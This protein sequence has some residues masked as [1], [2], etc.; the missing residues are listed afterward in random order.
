MEKYDF[1]VQ[2][3]YGE[4][5]P[6]IINILNILQ[7][8]P[9]EEAFIRKFY[10]TIPMFSLT[11]DDSNLY[12]NLVMNAFHFLQ[13]HNHAKA[14]VRVYQGIAQGK[15]EDHAIIEIL[16]R[17]IPFLFDSAICLLNRLNISIERAAHPNIYVRRDP[18]G[19]L[20]NIDEE[21]HENGEQEILIQIRTLHAL[22]KETSLKVESELQNILELVEN[23]VSD[24]KKIVTT[25]DDYTNY[26]RQ[27]KLTNDTVLFEEQKEFLEKM[28]SKYFIFL[29][30]AKYKFDKNQ[31]TLIENSTLGTLKPEH[32]E[33]DPLIKASIFTPSFFE[34]EHGLISIGK[35]NKISVIHRDA[36][37]DYLCVKTLD[38]QGNLKEAIV[39]IGLFTSILYY[40]SA[41]LIPIIRGKLHHVLN[42]AGF[43]SHSYAGKEIV[44]IVESLPRDELFQI[45]TQELYLLVMEIYALLFSPE[46][47]LFTRKKGD[48]LGCLLFLPL[49]IANAENSRKLKTA[50]SFEY[51]T[52]VSEHFAQVNSSRLGYY[53]FNIDSRN[54]KKETSDLVTIEKELISITKPWDES[55]REILLKE[56]GKNK[57]AG[58]FYN[59]KQA[60]PTSYKENSNYIKTIVGDIENILKILNNREIIFNISPFIEGKSNLAQF[61]IYN[62][63]ELNLSS[64]MPMLNNIG[65][66]VVAEQIH[67]ISPESTNDEIWLHQFILKADNKTSKMIELAKDN[68]EEAFYAMWANKFQNNSY[69][70]LILEANLNYKQITL[71]M[72]LA[73]YLC[74]IKIGYSKEYIGE[75][76]S[77]HSE[78]AKQLISL[79]Y[80]MFNHDLSTENRD[81]QS[82][83]F[84]N[85]L[86]N[87]LTNIQDNIE[88]QII[89][90][91]INL[92]SNILR[93]NYFLN[94]KNGDSKNFMSFKLNSKEI[95]GMPLP[96]PYREIFV[97]SATFEAIHLRGG[98][99]ARGGLRWSD[100]SEDYRTEVLGLMKTQVVKNSVIVPTGSKGGFLLKGTAGLDREALQAKA[101]ESYENFLRGMLDITDN[102]IDGKVH[103]PKNIVRYDESDPYL[104]VAADKGTATFSDIANKI[105]AEYGFW[106]GDAFASGG[107]KGYDHKKMGITAK[108][109]WISVTRHFHE[110][111]INIENTDF[112]VIGVGDMSG[113]V[114]GNG[115]L[116]SEHIRL[117]GAFN[118]LHIFI[119]P[120]P[121]SKESYKER[122]RLF[123]LP[124]STWLDYNASILSKGGQI[125]DRKAKLLHLTPEIKEAFSIKEDTITPDNLI[126]LL[127]KAPVDLLWNGGIGTYVKAS[128][129]TNEQVGDKTNDNLRCNGSELRCKIIGEGGNLG[130][131]QH[132]RIEYARNGGR[133]H[134]DAIDNSAGVDCSDHEVN[135][136]I[137]LHQAITKNII[138]EE[139]RINLLSSMTDDVAELVLKDNRT[140]T[141]AL[142]IAAQ[143]GV[144][145]LSAQEYFI[146]LLE[147]EGILDRK[148]ECLPSKVQF[149]QL[150]AK[151]SGLTRPELS[152]LLAYS[153]NAIYNNLIETNLPE[154]NYFYNDL[155]LYFPKIMRERFAEII[156]A[157][158]LRRE[159]IA[160]AITNSMV[161]RV[162]TFYLHL[163]AESTGH[164]FS[165]VARAY[166][167][168]RDVFDLRD[169]WKEINKLDGIVKV[170]DQVY[171]SI[172]IKKFVMRS[173][174]WLLRNHHGKID[175]SA[176]I[177][178]YQEKVNIISANI[179]NYLKG[180]FKEHYES[181]LALFKSMKVS[182]NLA[183]K[184]A[185]LGPLSSAYSI[186]EISNKQK[187][188]VDIVMKIYFELGYRFHIGWLR[189]SANSL[190]AN[191]RWEKLAL[192]G[193]KD[194]L[195]DIHRKITANAVE[196]CQKSSD[197]NLEKWFKHNEK[198]IKLFDK[199]IS[200]IMLQ[201]SIEYSMID[202]SLKKL[203]ILLSR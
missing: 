136:K 76:L 179:P 92:V 132:G 141:R 18:Q 17:E 149:E 47:R 43:N 168:T 162:D 32:K 203:S 94:D 146:D 189:Y 97:Y 13:Q 41:T 186:T 187:V 106:L 58:I 23:A 156:A 130:F 19:N 114:F 176:A 91:L 61:K 151:K 125:Y 167:I 166:T 191:N 45:S 33:F 69:N 148:L 193:F 39:F 1:T 46:L 28:K 160:T 121:D 161:N 70:Q 80:S 199:F 4:N 48:S 14:K 20:V 77:K 104:V 163:T 164:K 183:Q 42:K 71:L 110:L 34:T 22:D 53:Y 117:L 83:E 96:S 8:T 5:H 31:A 153:K 115:M 178:E 194:E 177:E 197:D 9:L 15:E 169:L 37:L 154:D 140:Q 102:I 63:E 126:K 11:E 180:N 88:D 174:N 112:T 2:H 100:R 84:K 89:R 181:D 111:G 24:W 139:E 133:L 101:I 202:L 86:E 127:L 30:S 142:T 44:S 138:N 57:G 134:T 50:L 152:V 188:S 12:A 56:Y 72:A 87:S 171:L 120:N 49:E 182:D 3:L 51:G 93:T 40:Q 157:H 109:A 131:T 38:D 135:I 113:D 55:L 185:I 195:Y 6:Y 99:V 21:L 192:R 108:G 7:A 85:Q 201:S 54:F 159:I 103:H 144:N 116:L 172:I 79:F 190:V 122:N 35:L 75:V 90:R 26:F 145:I 200:E 155:L 82:Q 143:Q 98:K 62:L 184:I 158:P 119:D 175:I 128:F 66:N 118:H 173:T 59:F 123:N 74:Q 29:G 25:L 16:S 124:R 170:E 107:S 196:H 65:F 36:M 73:E 81:K 129:E 198:H 67:I 105:S 27:L 10:A 52:I 68:I 165:D 78:I 60:F 64:I 95:I 147:E 137:A 150:Y